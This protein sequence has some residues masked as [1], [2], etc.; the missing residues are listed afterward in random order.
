[1][2]LQATLLQGLFLSSPTAHAADSTKTLTGLSVSAATLSPA[3]DPAVLSYTASTTNG[4]SAVDVTPTFSGTGQTVKVNDTSV[5][6]GNSVTVNLTIGV[7]TINVVTTAQDSSS[8]TY[9]IEITRRSIVTYDLNGGLT[10][11]VPSPETVTTGDTYVVALNS[12]NV[13]RSGFRFLG[14]GADPS[15][16]AVGTIYRP[17]IDS[18]VVNSNTT[19]YAKWDN[20]YGFGLYIDKP[21]VQN[22]YVYSPTDTT[23]KLE[24]ADGL[25]L[26]T[27]CPNLA[28]GTVSGGSACSV[29]E[30]GIYGGASTTETSQTVGNSTPGSKYFGIGGGNKSAQS[31]TINFET[32][33][34]YFGWWWSGSS[35]TD[36][37]EFYSGTKKLAT[38]TTNNLMTKLAKNNSTDYSTNTVVAPNGAAYPKGY[39]YGNPRVYGST[40]P[41]SFPTRTEAFNRTGDNNFYDYTG[42]FIYGYV[43]AFGSGGVTF[44]KV[45]LSGS[46][47]GG[48]ELDNLVISSTERTPGT[49]L[50]SDQ[51]YSSSYFV[52]FEKNGSTSPSMTDQGSTSAANLSSN[53]YSRAGFTFS[54]WN[55]KADGTGRSLAN[56]AQYSFDSNI[57]LYAVWTPN[58]VTPAKNLPAGG[59]VSASDA[60]SDGT[61]NLVATPNVG[62]AFTGWSCNASQT[63]ASVSSATTTVLPTANTTCTASFTAVTYAVTSA[64]NLIAGGT[65]TSTDANSDGTWDLVATPNA[66]YTFA[67]WSCTASQT[68]TSASTATTTLV[69]TA[70]TACTATFQVNAAPPSAPRPVIPVQSSQII[71]APTACYV[72][73][74]YQVTGVF[75]TPISSIAINGQVI[76]ASLWTQTPNKVSISIPTNLSEAVGIQI[77][78]GATPQLPLISCSAAVAPS[79]TTT[80]PTTAPPVASNTADSMA[81]DIYYNMNSATL[82]SKN[83]AIIK[84]KYRELRSKLNSNAQVIVKVT[85]WVQPTVISPNVRGLSI[86]RAK[87]VVQYMQSLGLRAKYTIQAPGHEKQNI[88]QSRRASVAISWST[89]K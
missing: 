63:P 28:I 7:N 89:A 6:S 55:T 45:V 53:T 27:T 79:A 15:D 19:L 11:T 5:T 3:F 46:S 26:T 62:Y 88:A 16:G 37:I 9:T 80:P 83:K 33:Q 48:F 2:F 85:G 77:F 70:D 58:T 21:F 25:A 75:D 72:T 29:Y 71:E 76:S 10:G 73:S 31:F 81:F 68:P 78:N 41:T 18:L 34:A 66:G 22:S 35:T 56:S 86:W 67:G 43:H 61:W 12:G 64:P 50:I 17:G 4:A 32:P 24:T 65:V 60:N 74:P 47:S 87:S 42:Q 54:G 44:N 20:P 39:Y 69:P 52:T 57:S 23:T 8:N 40:T 14:W 36:T 82:D 51:F 13:K 30:A 59:T 84:A 38:M 49:F 1:M